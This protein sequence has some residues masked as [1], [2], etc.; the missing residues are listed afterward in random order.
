M[1]TAR[2]ARLIV[3]LSG[4]L[5]AGTLVAPPALAAGHEPVFVPLCEPDFGGDG[6]LHVPSGPTDLFLF[7]WGTGPRG[8][9][10]HWIKSQTSTLTLEVDGVTTTLDLSD[11]WTA[12]TRFSEGGKGWSSVMIAEVDL[13]ADEVVTVTFRTSAA[14]P[15]IDFFF[16]E[17]PRLSKGST[18]VLTCDLITT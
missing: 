14:K 8:I 17:R 9:L 3:A 5:L 7:G 18:H 6:T 13:P 11:A 1:R 15:T 10:V 2:P 12:P 4:L 16:G